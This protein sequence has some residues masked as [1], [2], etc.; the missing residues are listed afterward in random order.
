V[1]QLGECVGCSFNCPSEHALDVCVYV[2]TGTG[3][4]TDPHPSKLA[5]KGKG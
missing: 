3:T 4:G 2:A 1:G 5:A